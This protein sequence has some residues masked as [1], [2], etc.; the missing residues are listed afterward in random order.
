MQLNKINDSGVEHWS[1]DL[2]NVLVTTHD[3]NDMTDFHNILHLEI[4]SLTK[5]EPNKKHKQLIKNEIV[6]FEEQAI[7][8]FPAQSRLESLVFRCHLWCVYGFK[9]PFEL[10]EEVE[11]AIK[12]N[13]AIILPETEIIA[14]ADFIHFGLLPDNLVLRAKILRTFRRSEVKRFEFKSLNEAE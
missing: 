6:G 7:E 4:S 11:E 9:F 5:E 12:E 14:A 13:P 10:I 1:N 2:Y 3:G 8:L